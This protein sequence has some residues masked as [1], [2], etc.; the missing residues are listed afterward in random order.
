MQ[1]SSFSYQKIDLGDITIN[2]A[3][4]GRGPALLLLHGFPESHIMWH[5]I[6]PKLAQTFTVICPDLRGYGDSDKPVGLADHSNYSKRTMANDMVRLMQILGHDHFNVA[7]HDRGARVTHRLCLDHPH[8]IDKA[9]VLDIVPTHQIYSTADKQIATDYYH[10]FF[11]IQP[12]PMPETLIGHD[13]KFYLNWTLGGWGSNGTTFFNTQALAEYERCFC[14]PN[15][16]HAM[17]EDYRA[18]ATID[19]QHDEMDI[20]KN[21]ACPL[22]VLWGK[23]SVMEKNYDMLASWRARADVVTGQ[24]IEGGHFIVEENSADCF[25]ALHRFFS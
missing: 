11:L 18:A 3:T 8:L 2:C 25:N 5:E 12:S 21:I 16:I 20:T 1:I 9:A 24:A 14:A 15:A 10:W 6:A 13:P 23:N 4:G 17:C 22:L 7:G 19:L